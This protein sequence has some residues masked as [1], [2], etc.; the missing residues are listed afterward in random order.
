MPTSHSDR[1]WE[2]V[3]L[4]PHPTRDRIFLTKDGRV[5]RELPRYTDSNGY[6]CTHIPS[7]P[8]K[9]QVIRRHTLMAETFVGLRPYRDAGV[10]HLDGNPTNDHPSNLAWGTQAENM[11]DMVRHGRSTRGT[12]NSGNKISE[13]MARAIKGR[14]AAGESGRSLAIEFNVSEG[15]IVDI[16]KGRTWSWLTD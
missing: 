4:H 5:F 9:A 7:S 11:A 13:E 1:S 3:V 8:G 16:H 2:R 10:R 12:R 6:T 14:R 15:T